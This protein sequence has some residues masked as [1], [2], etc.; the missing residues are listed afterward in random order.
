MASKF[1]DWKLMYIAFGIV[2]ILTIIWLGSVK[3]KESEQNEVKATIA[4]SFKL[5]GTGYILIMVLS[6][7]LVV[8]I[9]VAFN[10]NSGQFLMKRIGI[11]S[12]AAKMGRSV[13]FFGRLLGTLAGAVL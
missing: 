1:G 10:S 2:S 12:E 7:F 3:I 9:D 8:G 4:S 11:E 13:Y 5:L 6:I